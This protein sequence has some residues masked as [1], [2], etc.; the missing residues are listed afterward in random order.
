M[1]V[2]IRELRDHLSQ[3]LDRV[4]DGEAVVITDRGQAVARLVPLS[5]RRALDQ[6][7]ARGL[8]EPAPQR[9]RSRPRHRVSAEASVS[10]LVA[11]QRR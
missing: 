1:E 3:Y 10:E 11:D 5:G 6:L 7:I 8:V 4:R 9:E 2:G